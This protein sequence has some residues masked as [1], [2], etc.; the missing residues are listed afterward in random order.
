MQSRRTF[1]RSMSALA[2]GAF[3]NLAGSRPAR[4]Q[5]TLRIGELAAIT[6][7]IAPYGTQSRNSRLMAI[8]D[9][10]AKGGV[11]IGGTKYKLEMVSLDGGAPGEAVKVFERLLSVEKVTVVL[12]GTPSGGNFASDSG[13]CAEHVFQCT[14]NLAGTS[15]LCE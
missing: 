1:L 5:Q 11:S 10:N 14:S 4:A 7:P 6:G 15:Y 12:D 3:V 13:A 9:L 8:D 2:A